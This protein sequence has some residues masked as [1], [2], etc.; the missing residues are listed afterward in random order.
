M[1]GTRKYQS[2]AIDLY[3]GDLTEFVCDAMVNAANERLAGGGGI[4]GAI[5]RAGGPTILAE[6]RRIGRCPTGQAVVTSAGQL[7]ASYVIHTV[8]PVWNG[9]EQDE[10]GLLHAAHLN[11][12][13]Q[14]AGLPVRHVAFSA[15]STGVYGYPADQAATVAMG[16]IRDFLDTGRSGALQ[17]ITFVLFTSDLY[18][19]WQRALFETFSE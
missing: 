10:S 11:S 18:E 14:A 15:L 6:C 13:V 12:L 2:C 1:L 16:A 3:Q 8:G 7:P 5:H 9:G 17:R 4:D 19:A